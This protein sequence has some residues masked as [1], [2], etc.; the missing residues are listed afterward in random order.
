[1]NRAIMLWSWY[2]RWQIVESIQEYRRAE[3]LDP[4]LGDIEIGAGYAHLGFYEDWRRVQERAIERDPTNRRMRAVYVGEFYLLS[5]PEEGAAAQKRFLNQPPDHRYY[6]L[7]RQ[8]AEAAPLV[9]ARAAKDPTDV[10]AQLEL[11]LLRTLQG[12]H[13]DAQRIVAP[14]MTIA[15]KNRYYHHLT[16]AV[17]QIYALQGNAD[18]TARWLEETIA[19]GFPCYPM[20]MTDKFLAPVRES[21][22][23]QEVLADLK[24]KW[25]GYRDALK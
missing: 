15:R 11:A 24:V 8:I 14:S 22:R 4:A 23:V 7:T 19:W 10:G 1:L 21:P 17:A 20:F 18:E 6:L 5:L 3:Q 13:Q 12:R 2:E 16:Y 9:E 25:D